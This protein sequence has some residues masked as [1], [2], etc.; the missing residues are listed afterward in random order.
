MIKEF[1]IEPVKNASVAALTEETEELL[2]DAGWKFQITHL[3]GF[4]GAATNIYDLLANIRTANNINLCQQN[5]PFK[6][7]FPPE[8]SAP[9]YLEEPLMIE[10]GQKLKV[11]FQNATAVAITNAW[12][13]LYG[14]LIK[15]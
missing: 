12:A 15:E 9:N 4:D 14:W 1:H 10:G 3:R 2:I 13:I 11:V 5:M 7:L 6:L 8:S